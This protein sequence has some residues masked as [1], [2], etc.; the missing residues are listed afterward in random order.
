VDRGEA[1]EKL[2][3]Q[4]IGCSVHFIPVHYHPWYQEHFPY[5]IG[6]FPITETAYEGLISLPIYPLMTDEDVSDV[7]AAVKHLL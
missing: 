2:K 7:V 4:N 5:R 3:A 1:I 6:D